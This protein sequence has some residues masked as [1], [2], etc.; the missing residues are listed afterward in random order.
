MTATVID[1]KRDMFGILQQV[2]QGLGLPATSIRW[3]EVAPA[4]GQEPMPTEGIWFRPAVR[5]AFGGQASLAGGRGKKK[6]WR[7]EGTLWVQI[8][9][10]MGSGSV[11][12]DR[13]AQAVLDGYEGAA[14]DHCVWFRNCRLNELGQNGAYYQINVLIDFQYD[15][16][17]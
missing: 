17:K 10:P 3:E 14:T 4:A 1:A 7:R 12:A 16:V 8:F 15:Q 6:K 11:G 2:V 13:A 5:H 9:A